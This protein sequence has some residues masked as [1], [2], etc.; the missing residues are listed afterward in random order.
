MLCFPKEQPAIGPNMCSIWP[1]FSYLLSTFFKVLKAFLVKTPLHAETVCHLSRFSHHMVLLAAGL[2]SAELISQLRAA[3][4]EDNT[5][6]GVDV[7]LGQAGDMADLGIYECFRVSTANAPCCLACTVVICKSCFP[8]GS[9]DL[10]TLKPWYAF[11]RS[12]NRLSCQ[13]RRLLK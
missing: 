7:V 11:C 12:R 9:F 8:E 13:L 5:R 3:H 6:M 4:A 2:D 1:P 10:L